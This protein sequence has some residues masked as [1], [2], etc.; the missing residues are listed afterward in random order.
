MSRIGRRWVAV[1]AAIAGLATSLTGTLLMAG[2]AAAQFCTASGAEPTI[3]TDPC[4]VVLFEE[5][6]EDCDAPDW[7]IA[8]TA[9]GTQWWL[10]SDPTAP[11]GNVMYAGDPWSGQYQNDSETALTTPTISVP[12]TGVA[13]LEFDLLLQVENGFDFF[14]IEVQAAGELPVTV[15]AETGWFGAYRHMMVSLL[16]FAGKDVTVHFRFTSDYSIVDEGVRIDNVVVRHTTFACCDI[17]AECDDGVAC[18]VD[19]CAGGSCQ[20]DAS[21]CD[22]VC[23]VTVPNFVILL[24]RSGSMTDPGGGGFSK[25]NTTIQALDAALAEYA[26]DLA[27]GAKFFATPGWGSCGVSATMDAAIGST[28]PQLIAA[29][30]AT[31]ASGATPMGAGLANVGAIYSDP[32]T[33]DASQPRYVMLITDGMETCSGDPT[34]AVATLAAAGVE[35]FVV[36][37]GSGVDGDVL[38]AMAVEGGH[39]LGGATEYYNASNAGELEAAFESI[40]DEVTAEICDGIDNDCDGETDEDVGVQSCFHPV[41]GEGVRECVDGA[42]GPCQLPASAELCDGVD[43]NCNVV[44]D[45]PW[46]DGI[47][48]VL[49]ELC[50]AGAGACE[51]VGV[52]VCPSDQVSEARCSVDPGT[53]GPEAC[54]GLDD[55][56]DGSTDTSSGGV[57]PL[58]TTC[59]TGPGTAGLGICAA[60]QRTCVSGSYGACLGQVTAATETCNGLDDDC[61]G[62]TDELAEC[63]ASDADCTGA[64]EICYAFGCA[65]E[66]GCVACEPTQPSV[67]F[68]IDFGDGMW[69]PVGAGLVAWEAVVLGVTSASLAYGDDVAMALKLYPSLGGGTCDVDAGFDLG[70]DQEWLMANFL[71]AQVPGGSEAPL[72]DALSETR[73][74]LDADLTIP[75]GTDHVILVTADQSNCGHDA[76]SVAIKLAELNGVGIHTAVI[77]LDA[78]HA[79]DLATWG[80]AG[81]LAQLPAQPFHLVQDHLEFAAA[82]GAILDDLTPE[83]CNGLDDDCDGLTDDGVPER[84]CLAVCTGTLVPGTMS[85]ANG[86]WGVCEPSSLAEI[87]DDLDNDC[88]GVVDDGFQ[89]GPTGLGQACTVGIGACHAS[90][91]FVCNAAGSATTCGATPGEPSAELCDGLDNDCDGLT[92]PDWH[93]GSFGPSLGEPC[94]IGQGA[95]LAGGAFVCPPSGVGAP[96]CD[97]VGAGPDSEVCD[98]VD[99]DCDGLTDEHPDD[100][101]HPFSEPCFDGQADV[102]GVGACAAGVRPCIGGSLGTC[103]GQVLPSAEVCDGV[104]NDCDGL[105]DEDAAGVPLEE[106][107]YSG[108][109]GTQGTGQCV[110]GLR[111]CE[112]VAGWSVCVGE[113]VP[114]AELCNGLDD[115]C[116]GVADNA[117]VDGSLG[118]VLG[119]PCV[120]GL[121]ECSALGTYVCPAGG[122]GA[123]DCGAIS[124]DPIDEV[125]DGLD[126]DCDGLTDEDAVNQLLSQGCLPPDNGA[127]DL[128]YCGPGTQYCESGA[129]TLCYGAQH[130][131]PEVC[132]GVDN[133]CNGAT[134]EDALDPLQPLTL[135]CYDADAF[136][137]DVGQCHGG[138]RTCAGGLLGACVGQ[139]VPVVEVCDGLDNDCDGITDESPVDDG[140]PLKRSCYGGDPEHAGVGA[141]DFGFEPCLVGA[142]QPCQGWVDPAQETCNGVDDD[143][144]GVEDPDESNVIG[145][146]D[147]GPC[148]L[149]GECALGLCYCVESTMGDWMCILE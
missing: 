142:W 64:C 93:D 53:P 26:D 28:H 67:A 76:H 136:S 90:G 143:C 58:T 36:G 62:Q 41:C 12:A 146:D 88:N 27:V 33:H 130:A 111:T 124:A 129:W 108:A 40:L 31:N 91:T 45:D 122:A 113:V 73:S 47:G 65:H 139:V 141:C 38:N 16:P 81:G 103:V 8:N 46:V 44:V 68:L 54:N 48:P 104:D 107:C 23:Q 6:F 94:V 134:D 82:V 59:F 66:P 77:G 148:E 117:W 83:F 14:L 63:C 89:A 128:G 37:F 71:A 50:V 75:E 112:G 145:D 30:N 135:P 98:G 86:A 100:P 43:N 127:W 96:V 21:G 123:A 13:T 118:P 126:N 69:A 42:W 29:L 109:S 119:L 11:S 56:C 4:E 85:C 52:Y 147:I 102:L 110:A 34:A 97:A 39:G 35:T 105:T 114:S 49:G 72:F 133:D 55:D 149:Q 137:E 24:D 99:N 1:A 106:V 9:A 140:Q 121:G 116:D 60:G 70:W 17:D 51:N 15:L 5:S 32:T 101:A 144:D 138:L 61:D 10:Y 131:E 125:C 95:C 80:V 84:S 115:D 19:T 57:D 20:V 3:A 132:D 120:A 25:W 78:G 7:T 79:E 87:C 92:D 2:E 18:T 22:G 74:A